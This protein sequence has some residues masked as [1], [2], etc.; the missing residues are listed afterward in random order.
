VSGVCSIICSIN[1][2][3]FS[4]VHVLNVVTQPLAREPMNCIIICVA[5]CLFTLCQPRGDHGPLYSW[6]L[7]GADLQLCHCGLEY[8]LSGHYI[9]TR[10]ITGRDF[11]QYITQSTLMIQIW[12]MKAGNASG[13]WRF[14]IKNT[15]TVND[16]LRVRSRQSVFQSVNKLDE[17]AGGN[18]PP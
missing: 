1:A 10:V 12:V 14:G 9:A 6:T 16:I 13:L 2:V 3:S 8:Y 15:R 5:E 11:R 18:A 17:R 4:S 7:S